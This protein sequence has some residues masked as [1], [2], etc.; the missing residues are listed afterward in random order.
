M[1]KELIALLE[2][3]QSKEVVLD[4]VKAIGNDPNNVKDL[5]EIMKEE[6]VPA[7]Q[8]AAWTWDHLTL[9]HPEVALPYLNEAVDLMMEEKHPAIPRALSKMLANSPLPEE[10]LGELTEN[11]FQLLTN[12]ETAIAVKC[13]CMEILHRVCLREP[14]LSRELVM[15]I[16]AQLPYASAGFKNRG[17]KVIKD[18]KKFT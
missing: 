15:V 17:K 3:R 14:E 2:V 11:C 7:S 9:E 10:R 5:W 13:R 16:E 18:L 12:I 6:P 4:A 8:Y 1:K